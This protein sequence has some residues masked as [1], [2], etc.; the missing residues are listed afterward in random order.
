M[1]IFS[2]GSSLLAIIA[3]TLRDEHDVFVVGP[4]R[5]SLAGD[6]LNILYANGIP[7]EKIFLLSPNEEQS[8]SSTYHLENY[9]EIPFLDR[10]AFGV[11]DRVGTRT[12]ASINA[13]LLRAASKLNTWIQ[14][15]SP[16]EG[17]A[18]TLVLG[19]R[20]YWLDRFLLKALNYKAVELS[21]D[22]LA[23]YLPD[24]EV[25]LWSSLLF[26]LKQWYR[27][28]SHRNY[29]HVTS[30][31]LSKAYLS[32]PQ[33]SPLGTVPVEKI[34]WNSLDDLSG[35]ES[36]YQYPDGS[37]V[38]LSQSISEDEPLTK[39]NQATEID[40]VVRFLTAISF[41]SKD[42]HIIL[43]PH[44]RDARSKLSALES[45]LVDAGIR[46]SRHQLGTK[47]IEGDFA[48]LRRARCT[49]AGI[50]SASLFYYSAYADAGR[51]YSNLYG[52]KLASPYLRRV[53]EILDRVGLLHNISCVP[54][55]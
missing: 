2:I 41:Q 11:A 45:R 21:E 13:T 16:S 33:A 17:E 31:L 1:R 7:L 6:L 30:S 27:W 50:W 53:S 28:P 22:G 18:Q 55:E 44:P 49:L 38:Y 19:T 26:H 29:G 52:F 39:I 15:N 23:A 36:T 24:E 34:N 10:G 47:P 51:V 9:V 8:R 42:R 12:G 5:A 20:K 40:S 3:L 46:V 48:K 4:N 54:R 43:K 32:F 14:A 37:I 25:G 35:I